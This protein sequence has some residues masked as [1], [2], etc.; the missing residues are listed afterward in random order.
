MSIAN[1]LRQQIAKLPVGAVLSGYDFNALGS[2]GAIDVALHRFAK[3][4]LIRKLGFGLYD[5]PRKSKLLGDLAP[6]ITDIIKAYIRKSGQKIT[7]APLS[8]ANA[9]RLTTQVPAQLTYLTDGKSQNL[10]ICDINIKLVHTSPKKL[11][12]AGST[13][14]ILLQAL[15]YYGNDDIP[16][17][18]LNILLKQLSSKDIATLKNLRNTSS[19]QITPKI[20]RIISHAEVY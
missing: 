17:K 4:G 13:M 12:G 18:D 9:L 5:K 3:S 19:R 10:Q 2:R 7:L 11:A 8:A 14:G 16:D 6:Q 1:L 15:R 20:D